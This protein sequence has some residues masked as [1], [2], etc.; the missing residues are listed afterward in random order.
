MGGY[1][2]LLFGIL[3]KRWETHFP[4]IFKYANL[5][6]WTRPQDKEKPKGFEKVEGGCYW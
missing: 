6:Y 5:E 2:Q 1:T 4:E 3:G